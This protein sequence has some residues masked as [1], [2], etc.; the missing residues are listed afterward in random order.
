VIHIASTLICG[1]STRWNIQY[2]NNLFLLRRTIIFVVPTPHRYSREHLQ[3][4]VEEVRR[5][6][7]IC[8]RCPTPLPILLY[9]HQYATDLREIIVQIWHTSCTETRVYNI[10]K[11]KFTNPRKRESYSWFVN[12][13]SMSFNVPI[14]S[15]PRITYT[16]G[17]QIKNVHNKPYHIGVSVCIYIGT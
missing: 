12:Y 11:R 6:Q 1:H 17:G 8:L 15:Q 2:S 16:F 3:Y 14:R 5:L 4:S 9:R 13:N 7:K 10:R